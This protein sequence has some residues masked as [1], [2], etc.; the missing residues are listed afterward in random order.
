[1]ANFGTISGGPDEV[2]S[3]LN[4]A[5][6]MVT[7]T[8]SAT[9]GLLSNYGGPTPTFALLAGSSAIAAG[10]PNPT[11]TLPL[12]GLV[13]ETITES[14]LLATDQ[15]GL[16]RVSN[17]TIDLGAFQSQPYVVTTTS[18]S[19]PGSLRQAIADDTDGMPITFAPAWPARPSPFKA[20]S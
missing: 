17:G 8:S 5:A 14:G 10:N 9:F 7:V 20:S 11:A 2:A 6:G 12:P 18:N 1:M 15:R 13:G 19:G 3:G 16:A 4:L